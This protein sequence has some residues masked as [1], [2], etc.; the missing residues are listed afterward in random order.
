MSETVRICSSCSNLHSC[1]P[2]SD[3]IPSI[4]KTGLRLFKFDASNLGRIPRGVYSVCGWSDS[5]KPLL[6]LRIQ[7][8]ESFQINYCFDQLPCTV[9]HFQGNPLPTN[10]SLVV[11]PANATCDPDDPP[12]VHDFPNLGSSYPPT[13]NG[14]TYS[15]GSTPLNVSYTPVQYRV[16]WR[17][18]AGTLVV[19][20]GS[21]IIHSFETYYRQ[22]VVTSPDWQPYDSVLK[23]VFLS[24]VLLLAIAAAALL[25]QLTARIK[26]SRKR[27]VESVRMVDPIIARMCDEEV[28]ED[29]TKRLALIV[30][31]PCMTRRMRTRLGRSKLAHE[32]YCVSEM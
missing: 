12:S 6:T 30:T 5:N 10:G 13:S 16:C 17:S 7:G 29:T 22:Y 3:S 11:I 28:G 1:F 4:D 27:T 21:L 26:R 2:G 9:Q 19:P 23:I 31:E 32:I 15:F 8:I 25:P 14:S 20:A 24:S 18:P